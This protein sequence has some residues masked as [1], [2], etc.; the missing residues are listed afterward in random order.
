[1]RGYM[2]KVSRNSR[3]WTIS[4]IVVDIIII[5]IGTL[6][7]RF[8]KMIKK[9]SSKYDNFADKN[10]TVYLNDGTTVS[11]HALY[12]NST[13]TVLQEKSQLVTIY[14]ANISKIVIGQ[15]IIM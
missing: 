7:H 2:S 4:N 12:S 3:I 6:V 15:D 9:H 14:P 11:G 5:I 1:M 13:G 8:S 10:V